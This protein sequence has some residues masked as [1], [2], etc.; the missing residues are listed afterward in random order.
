MTERYRVE[1]DIEFIK[2]LGVQGGD[3]LKKCFQCAT[4]SV[5]CPISPETKP[6]PRKEMIAASWGLKDRLIGNGDV[7]LCHNCGDCSTMCPRGAKPGDVMAALR[8][9]TIETYAVPQ[10][11]Y[12]FVNNPKNLIWMIVLPALYMLILGGILKIFGVHWLN[13]S[14]TGDHIAHSKFY[15][16][17]LVDLTFIP[18]AVWTLAVF[19]ISQRRFVHAMHQN[20]LAEGKTRKEKIN[21]TEFVKSIGRVIP[22]ILKH[23]RFSDCVENEERSVSHMMVLFSFIG[24]FI[25]TSCFF[26][27]LYGLGMHGPYTQWSPVKWLGNA[28]A[29]ALIIGSLLLLKDRMA[30]TDQV[31]VYKDWYLVGLVIGLG[32]TGLLS[33]M[34]RLAGAATVTYWVYFIHLIFVFNLFAF[35][36]FTKLAHLVYRTIALAYENYSERT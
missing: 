19:V 11:L 30:K 35:T 28:S 24:L 16:T 10:K 20:A 36:P 29:V 27:A 15:H 17:W 23:R 6:F 12:H 14:P 31:S 26:I 22:L 9:K 32:V 18:L 7:W 3:N 34:T 2:E 21:V 5:V 13:L 25:V 33:E 4:C 1:P 8:Q